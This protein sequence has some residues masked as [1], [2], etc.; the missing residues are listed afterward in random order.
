MLISAQAWKQLCLPIVSSLGRQST[1][2]SREV[3][4][5]A[6][7]Q[8]QRF[9]LGPQMV[10][11]EADHE[12]VDEIFNRVLFPLVDELL[13]PPVFAR[14]PQGMTETRLRASALL[15]KSFMHFEVR[16]NRPQVDIRL[17]WIQVLDLLDRLMNVDKRDQLVS[18]PVA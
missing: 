16:D 12:Q 1:N 13:R 10:Y 6:I 8:L 15:C 2:A 14:D 4:H 17:L 3:R 7:S 9:L 5:S 18:P 11:D